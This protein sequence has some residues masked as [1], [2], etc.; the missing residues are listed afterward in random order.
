MFSFYTWVNSGKQYI[1]IILPSSSRFSNTIDVSMVFSFSF[2]SLKLNLFH[3]IVIVSYLSVQL[4]DFFK[5]ITLP[6]DSHIALRS[7]GVNFKMHK[8]FSIPASSLERQFDVLEEHRLISNSQPQSQS[9]ISVICSATF[10]R[11]LTL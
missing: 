2:F 7:L 10:S 9:S 8:Y 3:L 5:N 1:S 4:N 11:S 6:P